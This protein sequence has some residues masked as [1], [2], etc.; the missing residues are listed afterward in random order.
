MVVVGPAAA[1]AEA[2]V[3]VLLGIGLGAVVF[4]GTALAV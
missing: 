4:L 3:A 1:H 2:R